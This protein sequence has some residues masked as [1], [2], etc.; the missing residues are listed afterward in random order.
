MCLLE[1][2]MNVLF[3]LHDDTLE[4]PDCQGNRSNDASDG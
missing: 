1:D 4:D 2:L 3:F